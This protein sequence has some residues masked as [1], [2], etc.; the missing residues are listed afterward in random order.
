MTDLIPKHA[1][2]LSKAVE[3]VQAFYLDHPEIKISH[4][5]KH[6]SAV[7]E[8]TQQA[9]ISW[10]NNNKNKN[11][12]K[13][14]NNTNND[15]NDN[16]N[17]IISGR[18]RSKSPSEISLE[19]QLASL[20]H[21]LDD[22]KYFPKVDSGCALMLPKKYSNASAILEQL[23][24]KTKRQENDDGLLKNTDASTTSKDVVSGH[25]ILQMIS[26][27]SCSENGNK[28]PILVRDTGAYHLLIPRWADRLEAVGARGVVR[29]YQYNREQQEQQQKLGLASAPLFSDQSPRPKSE[30]ELWSL[31]CE[32]SNRLQEYMDR[33]GTST[34]M[35]SH[36]YDKLLPVAR[37][38][39]SIVR[40]EYLET[41]ADL[42]AKN[43]VEV[44]VRFGNSG[45][46]DEEYIH[47]LMNAVA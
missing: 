21:D 1:E 43:L 3:L 37:P 24:I 39:K 23:R 14:D 44:C 46:V 13:S 25:L 17:D 4:G 18:Q 9:L 42:G 26:W 28:V 16:D 29:C 2:I 7:W 6:V 40:N 31:L 20:L 12:N 30:Q 11:N 33:G 32:E 45:F 15:V 34:D 41:Q 47:R 19:V 8:H 27:V 36:Y 38:P 10:H 35:I 22:R 5:W